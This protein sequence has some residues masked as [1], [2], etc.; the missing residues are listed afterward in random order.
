MTG[1]K[2]YP[3][4][5]KEH[6]QYAQK[7]LGQAKANITALVMDQDGTVK[8]GDDPQYK[9]ANVSE[10]LQ[11]IAQSGKQ[12]VILTASGASALQSFTPMTDFYSEKQVSVPTFI[13]IGNGAALYRFDRTG[14]QKIY[15][16]GLTLEEIKQIIGVWEKTY[17]QLNI[18]NSELQP[19]GLET[20]KAFAERDWTGYI[21]TDYIQ[22]FQAYSGRCFTE[23]IKV[24]VVFPS[25]DE[26]RQRELVA[27]MQNNLDNHLGDNKFVAKRGDDTFL[28][29]TRAFEVDPKLFA[30]REII[31]QSNLD[32]TT[33]AAFG[34]MPLD[35]DK[36]LLIDSSLPFTFTNI[37]M[38]GKSLTKPPY[39][40]PGFSES[41]V[42][43]VYRAIDFLLK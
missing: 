12:P 7:M 27:A 39:I 34:D 25:W 32:K 4:D 22:L 10:L 30:L 15:N 28:H 1:K 2:K 6:E 37:W 19:K 40:L 16:H 11:R 20:F 9:K 14:Q 8:G 5:K 29:I 13:G 21:P 24:T 41:Q 38:P 33:I 36:G 42:G 17:K 3:P 43:C 26:A 31:R 35:N 18:Q 23:P